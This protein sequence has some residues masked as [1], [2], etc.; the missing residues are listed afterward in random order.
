[1]KSNPLF[2]SKMPD[3]NNGISMKGANFGIYGGEYGY[4]FNPKKMRF[5]LGDNVSDT[6]YA[7]IKPN[8]A[9]P[10]HRMVI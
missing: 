2:V 8:K 1:M 9:F 6:T 5:L 7:G 10:N 4:L 3:D